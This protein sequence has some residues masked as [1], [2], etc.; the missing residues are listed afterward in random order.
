MQVLSLLDFFDPD[1]MGGAARVFH[2][3]NR[4]LSKRNNEV[5]IICRQTAN[6]NLDSNND[7]TYH[8]YPEIEGGQLK[9]LAYYKRSI[10]E[11]FSNY[12]QSNK[13]DLILIHS[14]SAALGL[15]DILKK[16]NIP[17]IYYF[18]SPWH[19]EYELL[20]GKKVCGIQCPLV[21][22]L[23]AIRKHHERKYLNLASGIVT[24]SDA[25]QQIMR[26]THPGAKN[27]P[28]LVNPGA[29]DKELFSPIKSLPDTDEFI[30][31]KC[32]IRKKLN[33]PE[34]DFIIIS[35][36]RL[37]PRTGVDILIRAFALLQKGKT[38]KPITLILTGDGTSKQDLQQLAI[39]LKII[40]N[41]TFTGYVEEQKLADYYRCSDLFVMPTK[42][43]EGF[44][45]STVEAMASGLP[46][47]GTNVG[48][49][50][51]ILNKISNQLII[52]EC[53]PE[54]IADKISEFLTE[55]DISEW[56]KK[57]INCS[58]TYFSW[59]KHLDNLLNFYKALKQ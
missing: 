34:N 57:S 16:S 49:T 54:A 47:I 40:G 12:I 32:E 30:K 11:L 35:S 37:V 44:G 27:T 56:R 22:T 5:H 26:Q 15:A 24:L 19:R 28:M 7:I 17:I 48:G 33:I 55:E 53:S 18:H 10:K 50:P 8:T 14:S 21:S 9:K 43:L 42:Q 41:I 58:N 46:L 13:P 52:P 39:S 38:P 59:P 3:I 23:S 1:C 29:A 20:A 6:I 2:E 4:E 45:L 31:E 51:E 36:R 25:M